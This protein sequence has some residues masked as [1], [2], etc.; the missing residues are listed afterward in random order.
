[1]ESEK[2]NE[3]AQAI[4]RLT[5][6]TIALSDYAVSFKKAKVLIFC[7]KS[8]EWINYWLVHKHPEI[9]TTN[10][11]WL[12][13]AR[14]RGKRRYVVSVSAAKI[15]MYEHKDVIDWTQPEPKTLRKAS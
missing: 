4:E 5:E 11:G 8:T 3:L 14:G 7:G 1:M 9:L 6:V 10:G 2:N 13:P 15:W 12:T